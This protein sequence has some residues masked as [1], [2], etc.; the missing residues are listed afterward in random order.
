MR[1]TTVNIV[2]QHES[3]HETQTYAG[4]LPRPYPG[5]IRATRNSMLVPSRAWVGFPGSCFMCS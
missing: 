5:A 2:E 3:T 1:E 4:N